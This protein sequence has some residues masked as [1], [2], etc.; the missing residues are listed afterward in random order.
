MVDILA[1]TPLADAVQQAQRAMEA[2][3]YRAAATYYQQALAHANTPAQSALRRALW[4]EHVGGL[5]RREQLGE[6]TERARI[7]IASA[8]SAGDRQAE[9]ELLVLLS[10]ALAVQ[11]D[12]TGCRQKLA[13]VT[14]QLG[15]R[16]E[17]ASQLGARE[18]HLIRLLGLIATEEGDLAQAR[19]LF[20]DAAEIFAA[21]D[22]QLGQR[23]VTND[24]RR[25]ELLAGS[26]AA[27]DEILGLQDIQ[28][29]HE[30]LLTAHAL[31]RAF[32]YE[33]AARLIKK[34]L[35]YDV[36]PAW[37]FPLLHKLVLLYQTLADWETV[38]RLL[39]LLSE[40]ASVAANPAEARAAVD[41][42][43]FW[44]KKGFFASEGTGF[45]ARL[46]KVRALIQEQDL[47]QAEIELLPLHHEA[48]TP[49]FLAYW[50]LVA[51]ELA[52]A[53]GLE[54]S[55]K[56]I[57][58][59]SQQ[60]LVHL[61]R[62][63]EL[64]QKSSLPEVHSQSIR[65]IGRVYDR[66]CDDLDRASS[67]WSRASQAEE[68][69]AHR[70]ETDLAR[71]RYLE[72]R[73]TPY[74]ELIAA[75]TARVTASK[76][77]LLAGVIAAMETARGATIL[78][79]VLPS[80]APKMRH[81]PLPDNPQECLDWYT[82]IASQ[83]PR[84]MAVWMLHAT[85]DQIHHGIVGR[86]LLRWSSAPVHRHQLSQVIEELK[87]CWESPELLEDLVQ[88]KPELVPNLLAQIA[89][90]LRP[91]LVLTGLPKN[92]TR[93]A[94][95]AGD[96][97]GDIPFAALPLPG[98]TAPAA[99]LIARYALSDLPC[100]SA[101]HPLAQRANAARG[102][103]GLGIHPPAAN[104]AR[105][106]RN[107]GK[108]FYWL[109]DEEATILK[110]ENMLTNNQF[111]LVRFDCHGHHSHDK[112]LHSWLQ[113]TPT[114][115]DEGRLSAQRF[116]DLSLEHCGTLMLGACES[117][118]SQRLGRDERLGFVRAG[119]TAGASAVLAARWVAADLVAGAI[120][121]RFQYYLH[122]LPR[123]R[124][125]QQAQLDIIDGRCRELASPD[126]SLPQPD[127]PARWACWTLYG[128]A[129]LQTAAGWLMRAV[130]SLVA[131][132]RSITPMNFRTG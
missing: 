79:Q 9:L 89:R 5:L 131:H 46:H 20:H 112:A 34:R 127:H 108:R 123:D 58:Y 61:N 54:G 21:A 82:Q 91:E 64:A 53:R 18:P 72:A 77:A 124:A 111:P 125:L 28:N 50:S 114:S 101:R 106:P 52:L 120:L 85:D 51:G 113:L 31:Y 74:D 22:N 11:D 98:A 93:L 43:R 19:R 119:L 32:R 59:Q 66:L 115:T 57:H 4:I 6:G 55:P 117:G 76:G 86:D 23:T 109:Q 92:I 104:L 17:W 103:H 7:Y 62:A 16:S 100:L 84:T 56:G 37:R 29:T 14:T 49:R 65:L 39:P 129:G 107:L 73:S 90:M 68:Q 116:Q 110:L 60:A 78:S 1:G 87:D 130:R 35:E 25:L 128:D 12:W 132:L 47:E 26:T 121:N 13:E 41:R 88:Q 69:I 40:A 99:P 27:I 95:V 44:Q 126:L 97:L 96:A 67:Y 2:G 8:Q 81:L 75:A 48:K 42:L 70:Q 10:E 80:D 3:D 33:T 122:Y 118:M 36:E 45:E 94:I 105:P 71:I 24:L 83:L 30:V 15:E 63:V 102:D 38:Q